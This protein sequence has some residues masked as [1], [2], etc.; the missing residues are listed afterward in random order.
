[1][2]I[3]HRRK[4]I[5]LGI[6][7]LFFV[8]FFVP[9]SQSI[10]GQP[11]EK[12]VLNGDIINT[13]TQTGTIT[14]YMF[15]NTG[16]RKQDVV[17]STDEATLIFEQLKEL[18]SEMTRNPYSKK[19]QDLKISFVNML[20]EK[21]LLT[22]KVSKETYLSV[23]NPKWVKRLQST[24]K[25]PSLPQPFASRGTSIFC[26][27]GGEGSG[28]LLPMFLL[29]R[30]RIAMLWLGSGLSSATNMLTSRGY[31][32]EGAQAGLTLGFMGIGLSY[33]LPGYSLYGFI[34]YA[35]LATTTAQYVEH[36]PPNRAPVISDVQ[37][38]NGASDV[39]LTESKLQFRIQDEDG[40]LMSYSVTTEPDIGSASGNL[41]PFGVYTI[42][43]SGL[44][45]DKIYRW[46]IEVTDGKD[47]T[48]QTSRFFT[49]TRPPFDPF[50]EGWTYR[51]EITIDHT[52]VQGNLTNFPILVNVID[53]ELRD[54]A[55][56]DG[57]DILFME[58]KGV[59]TKLNHEID[60]F[61]G[62]TGA[63][64][65]W[66][67]I[68][69]VSSTED[70]HLYMYYGN[71]SSTA[72]QSPEKVWNTDFMAVWHLNKNPTEGVFDS[73]IYDNDGTA[74][75][76][77][78]SS[79]LIEGK[80]GKCLQ[81][82]GVND[83]LTIPDSTSL[84]QSEVTLLCWL[85]VAPGYTNFEG[86]EYILGKRCDDSF[87]NQDTVSYGM[88]YLDNCMGAV[89]EKNDNSQTFAKYP[90]EL[91][92][93]YYTAM[94]YDSSTNQIDYYQ[95]GILRD[96]LNHGQSLRYTDPI[97]FIMAA[98]HIKEGSTLNYWVDCKIDEVWI[99]DTNLGPGWISTTFTNQNNPSSF[100]SL[101]PEEPHP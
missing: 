13:S 62:V 12:S 14:C 38:V 18:N 96:S 73:T 31:V 48:T 39:P 51:K 47:T 43:I 30:P 81:F 7:F 55:Q 101:G 33:S 41:K 1:M 15:G 93:W 3:N 64:I 26:S 2:S 60:S 32:A 90:A 76:S 94:T 45:N 83:Y 67:K 28:L 79:N 25:R 11:Q 75:G 77:M 100:L 8:G 82:D 42:P 87:S 46:T 23:L 17:L 78:S 70:T 4:T 74:Y 16:G 57:D 19:T 20:D 44:Q 59:A 61:N 27:M 68:P 6:L 99:A 92:N 72:Q 85:N 34:G 53:T 9:C 35:L 63:M 80:V 21:G 49:Q 97:D 40:D 95:D 58:N 54:K 65:A 86:R 84:K 56:E 66:V 89:A 24:E 22:N 37:P 91:G 5:A 52:Q 69:M 98:G 88:K 29:P 71:S 36:Y 50:I 10:I